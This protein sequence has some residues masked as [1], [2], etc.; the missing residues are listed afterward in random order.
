MPSLENMPT[1]FALEFEG[2][3]RSDNMYDQPE[4]TGPQNLKGLAETY[5]P[6]LLVKE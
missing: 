1:D 5:V 6:P 3:V 4:W 2:L